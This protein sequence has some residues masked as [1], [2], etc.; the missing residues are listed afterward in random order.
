MLLDVEV[1]GSATG[2]LPQTVAFTVREAI[3]EAQP[4][5]NLSLVD[6]ESGR[7]R[8]GN[9]GQA[10]AASLPVAGRGRTALRGARSRWGWRCW[11]IN[12]VAWADYLDW[13]RPPS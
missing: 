1:G 3:R 2:R 12:W 4:N 11:C 5:R 13:P 10:G 6:V 9:R 8:P 7:I